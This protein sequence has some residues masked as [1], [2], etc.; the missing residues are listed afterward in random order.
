M[1]IRAKLLLCLLSVL[2]PLIVAIGFSIHLFDRQ[3]TERVEMALLNNQRLEA[4]RVNNILTDYRQDA[5]SLADGAHVKRFV[6]E[7]DE[8]DQG[9]LPKDHVVGGFDGFDGSRRT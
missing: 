4:A 6:G 3:F 9:N 2:V 5:N 8:I 7:L 1:G